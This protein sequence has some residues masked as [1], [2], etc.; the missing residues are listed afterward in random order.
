MLVGF[1]L[2]HFCGLVSDYNPG[3]ESQRLHFPAV[4]S[5][6]SKKGPVAHCSG[7]RPQILFI[8]PG[9]DFSLC[10]KHYKLPSENCLISRSISQNVW[11]NTSLNGIAQLER[12]LSQFY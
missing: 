11:V 5:R 4:L 6:A 8:S 9:E 2:R 7:N 10:V 12:A 1:I 3:Q